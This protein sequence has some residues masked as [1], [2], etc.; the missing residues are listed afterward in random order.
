MADTHKPELENTSGPIAFQTEIKQLLNILVHSLYT[1]REIFLRELLSN[2][3]DA[4]TQMRFV[5]QTDREILDPSLNLEIRIE[6][7]PEGKTLKISDTGI[8]MTSEEMKTNLGTIAQSGAKAFL[9][10]ADGD[11]KELVDVIGRFGVGFYS[12][13][14]AAEWVKV[15]SRSHQPDGEA[16]SWYATGADTFEMGTSEKETRGTSIEVKLKED[17]LEFLE[18]NRIREIIKTHS[19]YVPYPIFIVG[20]DEQINQQTAIWR[21]NSRSVK[22]DQYQDF[23]RQLTLEMEQ[24]LEK[25]HFVAD[26]PLMIYA[27]LYMPA[28]PDRGLFTLREQDGLKLFARKILIENYSKDLLPPYFRFIQGVVDA[29]DLPLNVSRESVQAT[30]MISR[31][32]KILTNQVIQKLKEM[33]RKDQEKYLAFWSE[34][35]LFLK[36]GVAANDNNRD[37]L[38]TL[39][40][41]HSTTMPDQWTSLDEYLEHMKPGQDKIYYIL[42]DDESSVSRSPHLDYFQTHCYE[43]LT[44]TD[45][46]DSFMLLGLREYK[47]FSLQ[48]VAASDLNLPEQSEEDEKEEQDKPPSLSDEAVDGLVNI[49]KDILG[50][51]VSDVR[52]TDRLTNSVARLVD[53]KGSLGQEMQRVYRIMDKDYEI[54]KKVLEINPDHP[55][56]QKI[57]QLPDDDHRRELIVEQVFESTLLIEGLHPDPASMIPRIQQL[58][59]SAL[60][61][62]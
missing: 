8:G 13:F 58:M 62:D 31:I 34:F 43:V 9:E 15:T 50:E 47:E 57:S 40:R 16:A 10:A 3:S 5:Q 25:I 39:L 46:V 22:E 48:N 4:L 52:I 7:D 27:L 56:L 12:V 38:S 60:Q 33:A 45:S 55:I 2:A 37:E 36:E 53:A 28:K 59:E 18:I 20:E 11:E 42:G 23:Y 14:M 35:G 32:N 26:A 30:A 44:L 61:D 1:K 54:P 49:F 29:E 51:R 6:I 17:A 21:E 41:F 24:P 19:D